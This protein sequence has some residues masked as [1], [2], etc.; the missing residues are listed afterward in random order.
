[1]SPELVTYI[2]TAIEQGASNQEIISDLVS[3]GV[4]PELITEGFVE[5]YNVLGINAQ[6]DEALGKMVRPE[7]AE[8]VPPSHVEM[9]QKKDAQ[10]IGIALIGTGVLIFVG[11]AYF[12]VGNLGF[13]SGPTS[14]LQF[15]G[16]EKVPTPVSTTYQENQNAQAVEDGYPEFVSHMFV[17]NQIDLTYNMNDRSYYESCRVAE[18]NLEGRLV[19][20]FDSPEGYIFTYMYN[21][22]KY[23][24]DS[25]GNRGVVLDTEVHAGE[26]CLSRFS[27]VSSSTI[28]DTWSRIEDFSDAHIEF[29]D[30]SFLYGVSLCVGDLLPIEW[31]ASE[32]VLNVSLLLH[33]AGSDVSKA[34]LLGVFPATYNENDIPGYG[35]FNWSVGSLWNGTIVQAGTV[36]TLIIEEENQKASVSSQ[37]FQIRQC[38]Q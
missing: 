24:A 13:G 7:H 27:T 2:V 29:Q 34:Q 9:L 26:N 3:Q 20:C 19:E 22:Q 21:Q 4:E 31:Y 35:V 8:Q 10:L 6:V 12:L 17:P 33:K 25:L 14:S 16:L 15:S 38:A 36:Y 5:A 11:I 32:D 18:A 28:S 1:M 37:W 23:C 30:P